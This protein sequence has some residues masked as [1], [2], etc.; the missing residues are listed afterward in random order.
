MHEHIA[1]TLYYFNIHLLYASFVWLVA[2]ALT[3]VLR[4]SATAKYWIWVAASLNFILPLGAAPDAMWGVHLKW[5]V[6]LGAVGDVANTLSRSTLVLGVWALG[7]ALMFIRLFLR[8]RAERNPR[9]VQGL[10]GPVHAFFTQG[11]Q[12]KFTTARQGP[13]VGGVLWPYISLPQGI[14]R[15]LTGPELDAVILHELTHARRRDNLIRL[16]YEI[17]LC[18]LWF[19]PLVW[20]AGKHLA[21]YRE[22]SCDESV[23]RHAHAGE[24]VSALAKLADPG[25]HFVLHATAS[26]FISHRLETLASE[27]SQ[28]RPSE[29]NWAMAAAFSAAL[30][31]GVFATVAHTACCFVARR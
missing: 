27:P 29:A 31:T 2:W 11:V 30:L 19:H 21:V 5:A 14:D 15:L 26:S 28:P 7:S 18:I 1:R 23:I 3:S 20:L 12:V 17:G 13:S 4:A 22:L 16:I 8:L 6:P 24:L 9:A 10:S 25:H